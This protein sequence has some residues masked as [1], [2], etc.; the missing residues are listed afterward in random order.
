MEDRAFNFFSSV[1]LSNRGPGHF[2]VWFSAPS[3]GFISN[4]SNATLSRDARFQPTPVLHS[5][6]HS[7]Q[8][9][10]VQQLKPSIRTSE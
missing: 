7:L 2:H 8:R 3:E 5:A 6:A 4:L 9:K 1:F 10:L